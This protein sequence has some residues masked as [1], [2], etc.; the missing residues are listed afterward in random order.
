MIGGQR[1]LMAMRELKKV[2][3][4]K[5]EDWN[6]I[7]DAESRQRYIAKIM[8]EDNV[9]MAEAWRL[10]REEPKY[11]M[12]Y[13]MCSPAMVIALGSKK[14]Q[15][16]FRELLTPEELEIFDNE[17]AGKIDFK[18]AVKEEKRKQQGA[19]FKNTGRQKSWHQR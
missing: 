7:L 11:S 15:A 4:E 16:Q 17:V 10:V 8:K 6:N 13:K 18:K 19:E 2:G 5:I 12:G 14:G 1:I 9:D 3:W